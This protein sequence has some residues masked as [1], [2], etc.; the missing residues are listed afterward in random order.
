MSELDEIN[1]ALQIVGERLRNLEESVMM[2]S[3][4]LFVIKAALAQGFA[5]TSAELEA[6]EAKI[7]G[8]PAPLRDAAR[9]I[10]AS[11]LAGNGK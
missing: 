4:H 8:A 2:H 9:S 3:A 1:E 5:P 11:M 6:L 10:L 7:S